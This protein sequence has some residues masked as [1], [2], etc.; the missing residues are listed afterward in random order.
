ME[1]TIAAIL[2]FVGISG[3]SDSRSLA[4]AD[5]GGHW[6]LVIALNVVNTLVVVFYVWRIWRERLP[7]IHRI[8]K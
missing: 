4:R 6:S 1:T 3:R 7:P 8:T 5:F 2:S